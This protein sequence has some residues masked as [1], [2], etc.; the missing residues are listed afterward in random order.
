MLIL[1]PLNFIREAFYAFS[2]KRSVRAWPKEVQE[3][4]RPNGP[5][6]SLDDL[7]NI[8]RQDLKK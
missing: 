3:R 1:S 7:K 2:L 6:T 8:H 5:T 4:L